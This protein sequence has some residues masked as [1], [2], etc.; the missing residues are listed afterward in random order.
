MS[1]EPRIAVAGEGEGAAERSM[2]SVIA[3]AAWL[4]VLLGLAVQGLILG[5]K[6][7]AGG[8][9]TTPQLFVDVTAGVTWSALVC[10]G[11]AV[12][13]VATRHRATGPP[14]WASS[15]SWSGSFSAA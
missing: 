15:T 9:V 3:L 8:H 4:A 10:S 6:V 1:E 12:G 5:A 13:T 2:L 11:I 7:A 14:S